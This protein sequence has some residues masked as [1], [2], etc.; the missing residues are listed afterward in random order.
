VTSVRAHH[1]WCNRDCGVDA[2]GVHCSSRVPV[3]PD[4]TEL[5]WIT[6]HLEQLTEPEPLTL[7]A[8]EFTDDGRSAEYR[9]PVAQGRALHDAIHAVL[10]PLP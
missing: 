9:L 1:A 7:L 10:S 6:V 3:A 2:I 8:I 4:G 5:T